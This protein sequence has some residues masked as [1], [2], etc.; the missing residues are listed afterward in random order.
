MKWA[1]L[2][3]LLAVIAF[4]CS[5]EKPESKTAALTYN[6]RPIQERTARRLAAGDTTNLAAE[7]FDAMFDVAAKELAKKGRQDLA[8]QLQ[9]EWHTEFRAKLLTPIQDAGDHKPV[10]EWVE[11]WYAKLEAVLGVEVMEMTHLR[12]IF[13]MN[14][15]IPVV[16]DPHA[17]STW[18]REE[19]S[20][21]PGDTCEKEYQRH[22]AGTRWAK[23]PDPYRNAV[24]H[25]GF[26]GVV[27]YWVTT[28]ACEAALW[29]TDATLLCGLAGDAVEVGIE[30]FVA[31]QASDKIYERY[32]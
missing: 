27:S 9:G 16:F 17:E 11:G 20:N 28:A 23:D 4:G 7:A 6:H 14:F 26:A 21:H 25:H 3:A 24:L 13:V 8:I 22:F 29:G 5:R 18:C 30:K 31:P 12:D 19:L 2:F 32:N 10:S 1:G 15:T